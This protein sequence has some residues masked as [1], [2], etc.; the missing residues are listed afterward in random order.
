MIEC[1]EHVGREGGSDRAGS[2]HSRRTPKTFYFP[3]KRLGV[4]QVSGCE[5]R[6]AR[7]QRHR[8]LFDRQHLRLAGV[9]GGTFSPCRQSRSSGR[10]LCN[11]EVKCSYLSFG[12]ESSM[13]SRNSCRADPKI[14]ISAYETG[15][16]KGL[17]GSTNLPFLAIGSDCGHLWLHGTAKSTSRLDLSRTCAQSFVTLQGDRL[18]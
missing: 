17:R 11:P 12:E 7:N 6:F 14:T 13:G 1:P 15:G 5:H 2:Q 8:F 4:A 10:V 18:R 3:L 16:G 9:E